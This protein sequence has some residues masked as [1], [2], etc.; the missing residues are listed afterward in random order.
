[1]LFFSH[2]VLLSFRKSC[3]L[4]DDLERAM[5][6]EKG[7]QSKRKRNE[8]KPDERSREMNLWLMS[9]DG[10]A[11]QVVKSVRPPRRENKES[12]NLMKWSSIG[13][14][15]GDCFLRMELSRHQYW[16]RAGLIYGVWKQSY[17]NRTIFLVEI[18]DKLKTKISFSFHFT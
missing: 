9:L 3:I 16:L 15:E 12:W 17:F 14:S 4:N 7:R 5:M 18:W 10:P 1:M 2:I 13:I 6:D 11:G 8:T